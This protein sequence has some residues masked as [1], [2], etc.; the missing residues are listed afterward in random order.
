[1]GLLQED[2]EVILSEYNLLQETYEGVKQKLRQREADIKDCEEYCE[3]LEKLVKEKTRIIHELTL[4]QNEKDF[5]IYKYNEK[6]RK[7]GNVI[8]KDMCSDN[9]LNE[10]DNLK[11]QIETRSVESYSA[12]SFSNNKS[13]NDEQVKSSDVLLVEDSRENKFIYSKGNLDEASYNI[14][15]LQDTICELKE[16]IKRKDKTIHDLRSE[17]EFTER[18]RQRTHI[19]LLRQS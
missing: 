19:E 13:A 17:L 16:T 9:E 3:E 12:N 4:Q 11:N 14:T 10:T 1:M 15:E 7:Q 2:L 18:F 6:E 8:E 5:D